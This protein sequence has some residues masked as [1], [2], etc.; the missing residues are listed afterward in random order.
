[1]VSVS[2]NLV[3]GCENWTDDVRASVRIF[4]LDVVLPRCDSLTAEQQCIIRSLKI[5]N[6]R[7][8]VEGDL[9][10]TCLQRVDTEGKVSLL[11]I[12][13]LMLTA[14]MLVSK[15]DR[16]LASPDFVVLREEKDRGL[17]AKLGLN[18][19]LGGKFYFTHI[20]PQIV[21]DFESYDK[22]LLELVSIDILS[23]L[24]K[25]ESESPGLKEK[26]KSC[27]FVQNI[28]GQHCR[29][30][31]LFDPLVPSMTSLLP[32]EAFPSRK[33]YKNEPW[34]LSALRALGMR[35]TLTCEGILRAAQ[36]INDN[37][38]SLTKLDRVS[39][40]ARSEDI[41]GI[42][43]RA[44]ELL[45]YLDN[46]A[47]MI[48]GECD[49]IHLKNW[50]R[51]SSN[52]IAVAVADSDDEE[53]DGVAPAFSSRQI[54]P[55]GQWGDKMRTLCWV[56]VKNGPLHGPG[57]EERGTVD[58]SDNHLPWPESLHQL[59]LANPNS[60]MLPDR[61][62]LCSC[63]YRIIK[64]DVR[65]SLLCS[66]LGWDRPVPGNA[67]A[68]QLITLSDSFH[69]DTRKVEPQ[70]HISSAT[71]SAT[72]DDYGGVHSTIESRKQFERYYFIVPQ[73]YDALLQSMTSEPRP[74]VEIWMRALKSRAIIWIGSQFVESERVAF[75]G[76][77][78]VD[79]EP[80]LYVVRAELLQYSPLLKELGVRD[81]FDV[82]DI[83]GILRTL[84]VQA[85]A[86]ALSDA[87]LD[88]TVGLINILIRLTTV[89]AQTLRQKDENLS[90]DKVSVP[91]ALD[92]S[93][94]GSSRENVPEKDVGVEINISPTDIHWKMAL[95]ELGVL[96]LPDS[97]GFLVLAHSLCYD[98]AS[99]LS[100]SAQ[101][102]P[103]MSQNHKAVFK[104]VNKRI[105]HN[106][107]RLLGVKSL[108]EQL[109]A[110][111]D[112]VCPSASALNALLRDDNL[113]DG[114]ADLCGLGDELQADG[115]HV[116]LDCSTYPCESIVHPGLAD[117]QG[118]ALV[119]YLE[120]TIVDSELLS[121]SFYSTHDTPAIP[122]PL[123]VSSREIRRQSVSRG[124]VSGQTELQGDLDCW[125]FMRVG[126]RLA[127][128]FVVTDCLQ[129]LSGDFL[130]IYDP[131]GCFLF[132]SASRAA[133]GE[134]Q[135]GQRCKLTGK[136]GQDFLSG[137][138]DQVAPFLNL[139]FLHDRPVWSPE[140]SRGTIIRMPIRLPS[141]KSAISQNVCSDKLLHQVIRK[142]FKSLLEGLL[143]F[144]SSVERGSLMIKQEAKDVEEL[145]LSMSVTS[146]LAR[147]PLRQ[148]IADKSWKKS[149]GI[150]S[151]ALFKSY[152]PAENDYR[153][154]ISVKERV[155]NN[156]LLS[157]NETKGH[158]GDRDL[159]SVTDEWLVLMSMGWPRL[160]ELA[161]RT[162]YSDMGLMPFVSVGVILSPREA[163]KSPCIPP[164]TGHAFSGGV[165]LGITGLP[166]H[167]NASLVQVYWIFPILI[168][169]VTVFASGCY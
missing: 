123:K 115:I 47:E 17:F 18:E 132:G 60:S 164:E 23:R 11:S 95:S 103:I 137:F 76:L 161:T 50:V 162:P 22:E 98:D 134:F 43:S 37:F 2:G 8:S 83:A 66:V 128:A 53:S 129:I 32:D 21:Y 16:L 112:I 63:T 80:Y 64:A 148:F 7:K 169:L 35:S 44:T 78:S 73:L 86:S 147:S 93:S 108:R 46:N 58:R 146:R 107:A 72:T 96:Y 5:W 110:G 153:V 81:S 121:R 141:A 150:L 82:A 101:R 122:T 119:I 142:Q 166:Y 55:G 117:M 159:Q 15:A 144:S 102:R 9:E 113:I 1:M 89:K 56:P 120:G 12:P 41:S 87:K 88:M 105:D 49:P 151:F 62:W 27:Q 100:D 75:S 6:Y 131:M 25:L 48:I 154:Q 130:Y 51:K 94:D 65:S 70:D 97:G 40:L 106:S 158:F 24:D 4:L 99:W 52:S 124:T 13:P 163:L 54:L 155:A 36:S 20:I 114:L 136:E 38:V 14:P 139:K 104:F 168:L 3:S 92:S 31:E 85:G 68:Q 42:V 79:T 84:Q 165:S 133:K 74:Y 26:L 160:R 125:D 157:G 59:E 167:L 57:R 135:R 140:G 69:A 29:P 126:K 71:T 138:P 34:L 30:Y 91:A 10:W 127:S 156:D 19:P 90:P 39:R 143:L 77:S 145:I 67:V 61:R 116:L 28:S 33:L 152:T 109:F 111:D 149:T 45:K 118:P